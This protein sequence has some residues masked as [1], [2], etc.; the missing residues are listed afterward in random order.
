MTALEKVLY[1]IEDIV[2]NNCDHM[3][4]YE[5]KR[6]R[7]TIVPVFLF[8]RVVSF[9]VTVED[10]I[11]DLVGGVAARGGAWHERPRMVTKYEV[12]KQL[13]IS[14]EDLHRYKDLSAFK[15]EIII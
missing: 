1:S 13:Y 5:D 2:A 4:G 8:E 7:I 6:H 10:K 15:F 3:Y 12:Q 9:E 14:V 11:V